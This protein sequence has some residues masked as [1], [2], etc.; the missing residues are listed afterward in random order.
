MASELEVG[1]VNI[2]SADGVLQMGSTADNGSPSL[3]LC[4]KTH[5]GDI[6]NGFS[7]NVDG[8]GTNNLHIK[9]HKVDASGT[10]A[11][12]IDRDSGTVTI[13]K[14]QQTT[15]GTPFSGA[16]IKVLPAN[17]TN[18][19]GVSSLALSTSTVDNHGFLISGHRAGSDGQPT[20]RI[21]THFNSDTGA[22]ALTINNDKLAQFYNGITVSGANNWSHITSSNDQSL[23]LAD[24]AQIQLADIRAGAMLIHIYEQSAGH[25][26]AIFA[27]YFG[28]PEL[29]AG[30]STYFD[31][32]DTDGKICVIKS[33]SSHDVYLKNRRGSSKN[34]NVLVTAAVIDN[35]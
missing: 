31:V 18:T 11:M 30:S 22:V 20:L 33:S 26:A 27:T 3:K 4:E 13:S 9:R 14:P 17:T 8:A 12:V 2:S 34:F 16:A 1:K 24:D 29:I 28:Q 32:A 6:S 10:D 25:G 23:S 19:T 7:F 15:G 21:S 5:S 35:F